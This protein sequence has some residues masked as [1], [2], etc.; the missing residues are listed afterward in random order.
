MAHMHMQKNLL[1]ALLFLGFVCG[2]GLSAA[3]AADAPPAPVTSLSLSLAASPLIPRAAQGERSMLVASIDSAGLTNVT[4]TL[5]SP[6]WPQPIT[7]TIRSL[8]KGK[9][10]VD[11]EVAPLA[12]PT[13]VTVRVESAGLSHEFGPFTVRPARKWTIY[14]TQH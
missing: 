8:P 14:L 10:A 1:V 3:Q 2:L 11:I 5:A 13:P 4:L 6:S 12:G 7:Q 9:Q